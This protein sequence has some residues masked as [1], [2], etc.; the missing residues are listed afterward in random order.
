MKVRDNAQQ[1]LLRI[2]LSTG[3]IEVEDL[4]R[5][6]TGKYLGAR[7]VTSRL[8]YDEV[9]R[10]IDPY[11]PENVLYIGTGPMD[12]L[13]VGMGR[14]SIAT[15][16]PRRCIGEG[17]VGGF[18]GPELRRAGYEYIAVRGCSD[19]PVYLFKIDRV[20]VKLL[21]LPLLHRLIQWQLFHFPDHQRLG[22]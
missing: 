22:D 14:L 20:K 6:W 4:P 1:R 11:G 17:S 21:Y 5:E 16:S 18:L 10:G 3:A 13:P 9:Q 12:G 19:K 7:G 2:N 8:L 15:K